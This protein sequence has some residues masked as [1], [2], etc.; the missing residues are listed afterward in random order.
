MCQTLCIA[1]K[2][3]CYYSQCD[4][5]QRPLVGYI[6]KILASLVRRACG[7]NFQCLTFILW[8]RGLVCFAGQKRSYC[9]I[10]STH[11]LAFYMRHI[12][13]SVVT[14]TMKNHAKESLQQIQNSPINGRSMV[15][16]TDT[17]FSVVKMHFIEPKHTYYKWEKMKTK[18]TS[19][20][21]GPPH[22]SSSTR[23]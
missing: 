3:I 5:R 7:L 14:Y 4:R 2:F 23:L 10:F 13:F 8:S 21:Q 19:W 22:T 6:F 17:F 16:P 15:D 20:D 11:V 12:G 18:P 1:L 9:K